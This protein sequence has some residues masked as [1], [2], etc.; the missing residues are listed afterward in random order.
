MSVKKSSFDALYPAGTPR[1]QI[2]PPG[3]SNT[4]VTPDSSF[5]SISINSPSPN[6][7]SG[8]ASGSAASRVIA[9][10]NATKSTSAPAFVPNSTLTAPTSVVGNATTPV[11]S[12]LAF[13]SHSS[14]GTASSYA[15]P[16]A[17]QIQT[18]FATPL[19]S[20]RITAIP[21]AR[22]STTSSPFVKPINSTS[23]TAS[24]IF[25][26]SNSINPP[27]P[28]NTPEVPTGQ[29]ESPV[30][31]TVRSR[32][33]NTEMAT[34]NLLINSVLLVSFRVFSHLFV[35]KSESDASTSE[36]IIYDYILEDYHAFGSFV[37]NSSSYIILGLEALFIFNIA[38]NGYKMIF[39]ASNTFNDVKMTASQRK[40]LDLPDSPNAKI[41]KE[42][43]N[44]DEPPKYQK[45]SPLSRVS[46]SVK[47]E[48]NSTSFTASP[49]KALIASPS[50]NGQDS[51]AENSLVVRS[52]PGSALR[53]SR[54]ILGSPG[55]T[56]P[57]SPLTGLNKK[58]NSP[59][60]RV[61][62]DPVF[63]TIAP[64]SSI[65]A[66]N[67]SMQMPRVSYSSSSN[68]TIG[69]SS[70]AAVSATSALAS[71][72]LRKQTIQA[73]AAA[74]SS[75]LAADT[76]LSFANS[77]KSPMDASGRYKY[78]AQSPQRVVRNI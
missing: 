14:A 73:A 27:K 52:N 29:W 51:S 16:Q 76:S 36:N 59:S 31:K 38:V 70:S 53:T 43:E 4:T 44:L 1:R 34:R 71:P 28:P 74:V 12:N 46:S 47:S 32:L 9:A 25:N 65:D 49:F 3:P 13:N 77:P 19:S 72:S 69:S 2:I 22:Y 45:A 41:V 66:S 10:A 23:H 15:T 75:P 63:S 21:A 5:F 18:P 57:S 55:L 54:H 30:M 8:L 68:S 60:P 78:L 50:R 64:K 7:P 24:T 6:F 40:I 61:S 33:V 39:Q 17:Q 67:L 42:G 56:T 48:A 26:K 37:T 20:N 62:F 35:A 11:K 58:L